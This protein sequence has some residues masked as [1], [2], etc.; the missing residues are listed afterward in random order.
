MVKSKAAEAQQ[1]NAA[2]GA[3]GP[4]LKGQLRARVAQVLRLSPDQKHQIRAVMATEKDKRTTLRT[5]VH[6]ARM[7]LRTT[8]R[9]AG[10]SENDIRAASAKVAS[11]EADLAVERAALFGRISPI[12]TADQLA[13]LNRLQE[14]VDN[15]V[16][17]AIIGS[18]RRLTN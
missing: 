5:A 1:V 9:T 7:N 12:L 14:R 2:L 8:I 10:S 16:D 18:G 3:G 17:G 6:D 11:A 13:R 15:A 4:G